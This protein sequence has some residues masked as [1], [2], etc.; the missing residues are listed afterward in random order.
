M[1]KGMLQPGDV[2]CVYPYA[3]LMPVMHIRVRQ[4]RGVC[5]FLAFGDNSGFYVPMKYIKN[6]LERLWECDEREME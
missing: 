2:V 4:N 5:A 6:T 3:H 1:I